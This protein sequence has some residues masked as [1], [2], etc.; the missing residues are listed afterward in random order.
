MKTLVIGIAGPSGGGKSTI[1]EELAQRL[2]AE[3]L[4]MDHYFR[5]EMPMMVS[6]ADGESYPDWN[7]PTSVRTE[8][9]AEDIR[10]RVAAGTQRYLIVEGALLLAVEELRGLLDLKVFVDASIETCLYRRIVRNVKLMGQTPE[11]IGG[12]YLKCVRHREAEFTRPSVK[13]ADYVIDNDVSWQGQLEKLPLW[14]E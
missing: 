10:L 1:A 4:H 11:F 8:Q 2:G 3:V 7:H 13:Y 14:N 9:L 5:E 12:Y 6:P